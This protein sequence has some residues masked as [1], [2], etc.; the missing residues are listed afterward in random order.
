ME[1]EGSQKAPYWKG[2]KSFISSTIYGM[3]CKFNALADKEELLI[4]MSLYLPNTS[5]QF[6]FELLTASKKSPP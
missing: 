5:L 6:R 2:A 1:D 3:A 4:Q